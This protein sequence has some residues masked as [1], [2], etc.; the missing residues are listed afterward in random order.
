MAQLTSVVELGTD[1][2]PLRHQESKIEGLQI[3]GQDV[4]LHLHD[5]L[6]RLRRSGTPS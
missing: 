4:K 1:E 6:S 5:G 2:T 3:N